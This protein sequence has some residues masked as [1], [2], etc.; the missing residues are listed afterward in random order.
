MKLKQ[1]RPLTFDD[2]A[3]FRPDGPDPLNSAAYARDFNEVKALGRVD[4]AIRTPTQ[5]ETARFWSEQTM[6]QRSRTVR[7]LAL[8]RHLNLEETAKL[9]AMAHVS[10]GD[11]AVG[12]W[13]AKYYFN[14]W[15]PVHAIQP[16]RRTAT[17]TPRGRGLDSPAG[18]EP[19]GVPVGARVR[20]GR[21]HAR[22][23]RLL[24][25][26]P[27]RARRR[28]HGDRD[29]PPLRPA[30]R[31]PRGGRARADLRGLHFRHAMEDGEQIG[32][33]R[34]AWSVASSTDPG[35]GGGAAPRRPHLRIA[36]GS[37]LGRCASSSTPRRRSPSSR[38]RPSRTGSSSSSPMTARASRPSPRRR[39]ARR[40]PGS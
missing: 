31:R 34:P 28:Q 23:R 14:F 25:H 11:S 35:P 12:C 18:R 32:G 15:R 37:V 36:P 19:S 39:P 21:G 33:G 26:R 4:S 3:R 20:H 13:D 1:V 40:R 9:M 5:T 17:R 38:A 27:R 7:T 24:R 10:G 6:V 22:D 30:A 8:A 2:A 29:D 16:R